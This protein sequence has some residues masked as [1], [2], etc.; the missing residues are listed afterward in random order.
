MKRLLR[1]ILMAI[2]P[3][4]LA[5]CHYDESLDLCTLTVRLVYP[6]NSDVG[7]YEGARVELK[8]QGGSVFVDST[9]AQGIVT[10]RLPSGVYEAS[11][12][13]QFIDSTG[14]TWWRYNFNGVKSLIVVWPDSVNH[15]DVVL[16][17]SKKRVVH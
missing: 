1:Y 4:L 2:V 8:S 16:K 13:S 11:S 14:T 17:M 6:E 5:A 12:S 3:M 9:N 10:W 15:A 7:P